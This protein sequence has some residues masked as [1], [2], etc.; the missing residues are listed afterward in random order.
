MKLNDD[1]EDELNED[2]I[3]ICDYY[4]LNYYGVLVIFQVCKT[5]K[6]S[7][8]LIELATKIIDN[9]IMLTDQVRASKKPLV[10]REN[11][12][13]TKSTYEVKPIRLNGKDLWLPIKIDFGD[14]IFEEAKKYEPYPA[15]GYAYAVPMKIEEV[16]GIYWEM[17]EKLETKKRNLA[18]RIAN[19]A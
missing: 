10:I 15:W 4:M 5:R 9:K 3:F 12:V 13:F 6:K 2:G 14:P 19:L 18:K 8:F 11:N 1:M 16:V 17:P 7:V